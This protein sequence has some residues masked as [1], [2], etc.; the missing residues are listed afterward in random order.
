MSLL[1]PLVITSGT[2]VLFAYNLSFPA[3]RDVFVCSTLSSVVRHG[4]NKLSLSLYSPF[5]F[6]K[7]PAERALVVVTID[8]N[9]VQNR[10][11]CF[12]L[13]FFLSHINPASR[14]VISCSSIFEKFFSIAI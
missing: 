2:R 13:P 8:F 11:P 3:A 14:E 9:T 6:S 10:V 7:I 1:L 12:F 5:F 4:I